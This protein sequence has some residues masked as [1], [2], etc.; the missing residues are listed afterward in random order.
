MIFVITWISCILCKKFNCNFNNR[1][2]QRI[3]NSSE[4][5]SVPV[6]PDYATDFVSDYRK[7]LEADLTKD[8]SFKN[9]AGSVDK[10]K[11]VLILPH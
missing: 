11:S 6:K 9:G 1:Q 2:R 4:L 8:T 7:S 10:T 5:P 3:E